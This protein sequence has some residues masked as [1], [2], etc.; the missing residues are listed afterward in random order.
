MSLK[1]HQLAIGLISILFCFLS[2][3]AEAQEVSQAGKVPDEFFIANIPQLPSSGKFR[4]SWFFIRP[5]FA[6]VQGELVNLRE[7]EWPQWDANQVPA[8]LIPPTKTKAWLLIFDSDGQKIDQLELKKAFQSEKYTPPENKKPATYKIQVEFASGRGRMISKGYPW[9]QGRSVFSCKI[10]VDREKPIQKNAAVRNCVKT[11]AALPLNATQQWRVNIQW[12]NLKDPESR[13]WIGEQDRMQKFLFRNYKHQ[14]ESNR[15][16]LVFQ[17]DAGVTDVEKIQ[18]ISFPIDELQKS[19]K[20]ISTAT[21]DEI[22]KNIYDLSLADGSQL[23]IRSLAVDENELRSIDSPQALS[24]TVHLQ[25]VESPNSEWAFQTTE[26]LEYRTG[27]LS[28]ARPLMV[29]AYG[30]YNSMTSSRGE[31]DSFFNIPGVEVNWNPNLFGVRPYLFFES[32]FIHE[33]S[34]LSIGELQMGFHKTF[35]KWPYIKPGLGFQQYTLSGKN[36][37]S[38]R[39]GKVN[40]IVVSALT[41]EVRGDVFLRGRAQGMFASSQGYAVQLEAGKMFKVQKSDLKVFTSGILGFS[42]YAAIATNR[43]EVA[44]SFTEDRWKV[45]LEIGLIGPDY[46]DGR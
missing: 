2:V 30:T 33:G 41:E 6:W 15:Q 19:E 39:L 36:P 14:F 4:G 32:G 1:N 12:P 25:F 22:E 5:P 38:S 18:K 16:G 45:G 43:L 20:I 11:L 9:R 24:P 3:F 46:F 27:F 10:P 28:F 40:A 21:R 7:I 8:A 42:R 44:E 37:G 34:T 31:K 26:F 29:G 17:V 13:L 35:E 23:T